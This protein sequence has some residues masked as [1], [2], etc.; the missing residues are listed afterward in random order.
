MKRVATFAIL[1]AICA[2]AGV[3]P[4]WI[5]VKGGA[6]D[7]SEQLIAEVRSHIQEYVTSEANRTGTNLEPWDSYQFQFRGQLDGKK[8]VIF[9]NGFCHTFGDERL[10]EGLLLVFDGGPCY[11]NLLYD[12]E[13]KK[14]RSLMFNG[15]A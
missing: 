9:I 12:S 6:W 8:R 7:P 11:F 13:T 5:Q 4:S 3:Q 1:L 14:F 2:N 15:Y 10:E